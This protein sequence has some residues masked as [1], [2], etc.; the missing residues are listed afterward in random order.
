MNPIIE[1]PDFNGVTYS[2]T[3][4]DLRWDAF[5]VGGWKSFSVKSPLKPG[6]TWG[7]RAKPRARTT[8]KFD[9]TGECEIY[10]TYFENLKNYLAAKGLP[11]GLGYK[12]V[13][14]LVTFTAFEVERGTIITEVFGVRISDEDLSV[15][16]GSDDELTVKLTL[17]V[18]DVAVNG[19]LS[20]IDTNLP[21]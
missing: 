20:V 15:S 7:N 16:D 3:S 13:S 11:F 12:Q 2:R 5:K 21:I 1:D 4:C 17:D 10:L 14:S 8:G 19:V 6:K 9:P 18:M